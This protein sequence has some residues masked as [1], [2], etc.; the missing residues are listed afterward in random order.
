MPTGHQQLFK[1]GF[2]P[3]TIET[4]IG[5]SQTKVESPSDYPNLSVK[6]GNPWSNNAKMIHGMRVCEKTGQVMYM[7]SWQQDYFQYF[8]TPSW[9]LSQ[10]IMSGGD[11]TDSAEDS[12]S[13]NYYKLIAEFYHNF[14][15]NMEIHKVEKA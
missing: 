1:V 6:M 8:Y 5:N 12:V 4:H 14:A 3:P 15:E 11:G 7:C 9:V 2:R 10:T 13:Q